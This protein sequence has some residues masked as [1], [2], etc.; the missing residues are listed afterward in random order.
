MAHVLLFHH[1]RGL[2]D[3]VRAFADDLRAAG[4]EVTVPDLYEG[5]TFPTTEEGVAHA[6]ELGFGRIIDRGVEAAE[7]L[8]AGIVYAGFSLGAMPAQRLAQQRAGARG[9]VL[10]HSAAPVTEF[11]E[12]WPEGVPL[13]LHIMTDDPWDD[14]EVMEG[15]AGDGGELFTYDGDAH[16]FTDRSTDDYDAGA[17]NLVLERTLEFLGRLD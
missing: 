3:G 9:A 17:A 5:R 15:L 11:G 10:Y 12:H 8:P 2:T 13:Q 7:R 6:E 16:L 1:A 14:L 4:H